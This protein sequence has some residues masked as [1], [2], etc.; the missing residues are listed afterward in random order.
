M[1]LGHPLQLSAVA[2][3]TGLSPL[4]HLASCS[5]G[6]ADSFCRP[7]VRGTVVVLSLNQSVKSH[8]SKARVSSWVE[9]VVVALEAL[10]S[11]STNDDDDDDDE[12][13]MGEVAGA[14]VA[15]CNS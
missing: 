9:T 6:T 13:S 8:R 10:A 1:S 3:R 2:A 12:G 4:F 15:A 5:I 7:L 14:A 11:S